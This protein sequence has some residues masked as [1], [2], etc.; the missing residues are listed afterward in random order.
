MLL[1]LPVS[2]TALLRVLRLLGPLTIAI[3]DLLLLN[4]ILRCFLRLRFLILGCCFDG[5]S[6][7][8]LI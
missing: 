8:E 4:V 6:A 1:V 7:L 2:I 5:C 3:L